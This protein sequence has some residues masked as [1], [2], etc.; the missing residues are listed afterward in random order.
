MKL[1][2]FVILSF[3]VL[4][5]TGC[6]GS[7]WWSGIGAGRTAGVDDLPAGS[8]PASRIGEVAPYKYRSYE[9]WSGGAYKESGMVVNIQKVYFRDG[10]I[11]YYTSKTEFTYRGSWVNVDRIERYQGVVDDPAG[12]KAAGIVYGPKRPN[13]KK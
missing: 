2:I 13:F 1:M 7:K 4:T 3:F 5:S 10:R 9:S 6:A 12:W 8:M 11:T